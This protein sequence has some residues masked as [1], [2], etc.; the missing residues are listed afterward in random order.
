MFVKQHGEF[1]KDQFED[2]S[3]KVSPD[4]DAPLRRN[5]RHSSSSEALPK[6]STLVKLIVDTRVGAE[7]H[8]RGRLQLS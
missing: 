6:G 5:R 7:P 3:D 8:R 1:R 2:C 4:Y